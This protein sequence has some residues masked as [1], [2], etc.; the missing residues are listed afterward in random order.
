MAQNA[1]PEVEEQLSCNGKSARPKRSGEF[2]WQL[3]TSGQPDL[4][5]LSRRDAAGPSQALRQE[6]QLNWI[7]VLLAL[8]SVSF[9]VVA[10]PKMASENPT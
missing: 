9:V 3:V 8:R 1:T 7:L 6:F 5:T 4:A 2:D 10:L